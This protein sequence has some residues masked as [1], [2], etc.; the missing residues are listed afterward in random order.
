MRPSGHRPQEIAPWFDCS[1]SR[2]LQSLDTVLDLPVD[3]AGY[4][5]G[6][7][8]VFAELIQEDNDVGPSEADIRVRPAF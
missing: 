3:Y 2:P 6:G 1:L 7:A 8:V 5:H 4:V